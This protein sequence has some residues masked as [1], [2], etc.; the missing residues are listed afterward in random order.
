MESATT[1]GLLKTYVVI[2]RTSESTF[3]QKVKSK[4]CGA[5]AR[6][7][8]ERLTLA[9]TTTANTV[10]LAWAVTGFSR[11][12]SGSLTLPQLCQNYM[13]LCVRIG[14]MKVAQVLIAVGAHSP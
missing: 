5:N 12:T 2:D 4:V 14:K 7:G 1:V 13:S 6:S 9:W 8:S 3:A 11:E 10:T